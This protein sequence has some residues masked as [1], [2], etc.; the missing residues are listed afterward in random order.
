MGS[1]SVRWGVELE[2]YGLTWGDVCNI[3]M[4]V[5]DDVCFVAE[6]MYG[7]PLNWIVCHDGSIQG[8]RPFELKSPAFSG[9]EEGFS[10]LK[11]ITRALR[12]AGAAVNTSCGLHVH[13][14]ASYILKAIGNNK[15][16]VAL[17]AHMTY[18][19]L[20]SVLDSCVPASRRGNANQQCITMKN[21]ITREL[22]KRMAEFPNVEAITKIVPINDVLSLDR[23]GTTHHI[24]LNTLTALQ[25]HW[26]LEYRHHS[27][28]LQASK[29]IPWIRLTS[30]IQEK[31]GAVVLGLPLPEPF[32]KLGDALEWLEAEPTLVEY[33]L[34]RAKTLKGKEEEPDH[35]ET[36]EGDYGGTNQ[37]AYFEATVAGGKRKPY[38]FR[39][40]DQRLFRH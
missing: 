31:I 20:E 18:A 13:Q 15:R 40:E 29:I 11:S 28:T 22:L 33:W 21:E 1:K 30:L 35:I 32:T 39:E 16:F 19:V 27:G 23:H 2:G 17:A 4:D 24:K 8:Q 5:T 6:R 12:K 34:E 3:V 36:P 14:E 9:E 10:K 7:N 26:T 25:K 37:P 38:V